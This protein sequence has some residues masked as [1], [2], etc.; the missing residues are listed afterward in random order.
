MSESDIYINVTGGIKIPEN[1]CDL[2]I[3]ASIISCYLNK[4]LPEDM[5]FF[6]EIGLTGEIRTVTMAQRRLSESAKMGFKRCMLPF[7]SLGSIEKNNGI[8]IVSV[9]NLRDVVSYIKG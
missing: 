9:K 8:E 5:T 1:A 6:G 2:G 7:D 4:P 3:A